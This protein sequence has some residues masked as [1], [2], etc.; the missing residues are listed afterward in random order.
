M[1]STQAMER[2]M[3]LIKFAAQKLRADFIALPDSREGAQA[4]CKP[5][6]FSWSVCKR[7]RVNVDQ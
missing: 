7:R 5:C 3:S 2:F 6:S 1:A 4:E